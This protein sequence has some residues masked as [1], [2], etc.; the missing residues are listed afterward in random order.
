[1][2]KFF[3]EF[4]T[5]VTRGNVVDMAVGVIV[6]AAFTAIVNALSN[7]VLKPLINWLLAELLGADNAT[8][9]H[10]MLKPVYTADEA[11]NSVL[12][13]TQSIYIDWGA[14][15]NAVL[16]FFIVAMTL[17]IIVRI[18]NRVRAEHVELME[19]IRRVHLDRNERRELRA[20][21]ISPRDR[22]AVRAY[23]AEKAQ[24]AEAERLAAE[25]AARAAAQ[26]AV[27]VERLLGEIRDLLAKKA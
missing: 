14:F 18:A 22:E 17:F 26:N 23:F 8:E 9:L 25:E 13:L 20:A 1:M 4:K 21:G 10:T 3:G 16:S 24:R 2:K 6:G 7:N 12:D 19:E 11:G 27:T 15:I 5:F